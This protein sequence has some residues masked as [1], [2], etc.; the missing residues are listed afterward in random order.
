VAIRFHR[1]AVALACSALLLTACETVEQRESE[2][3]RMNVLNVIFSWDGATSCAK[4][5]SP[6]FVVRNIPEGT[7]TLRFSLS[8]QADPLARYGGGDVPYTP[9]G[10]GLATIT[11]GAFTYK[12]PCSPEI[13]GMYKWTVLALDQDGKVL[14]GGWAKKKFP[15]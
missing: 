5:E 14:V 11:P 3:A 7:R 8:N 6:P 2:E 1:A 4:S 13:V 12:G 15:E 9:N 10:R